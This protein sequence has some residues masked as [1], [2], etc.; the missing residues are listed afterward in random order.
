MSDTTKLTVYVTEELRRALRVRAAE[1]GESQSAIAE[2]A[3]R[4]ELGMMEGMKDK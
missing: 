2:R 1:T 3:L 4:R